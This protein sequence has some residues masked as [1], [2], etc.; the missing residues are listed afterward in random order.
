VNYTFNAGQGWW[1]TSG[2]NQGLRTYNPEIEV[3]VDN[4]NAGYTAYYT[5]GSPSGGFVTFE[6]RS[7]T[8]GIGSMIVVNGTPRFSKTEQFSVGATATAYQ[9]IFIGRVH[10]T[11]SQWKLNGSFHSYNLTISPIVAGNYQAFYTFNYVVPPADIS[12]SSNP[13][14][15]TKISW[16]PPAGTLVDQIQVWRQVRQDKQVVESANVIATLSPTAEQYIDY[17]YAPASGWSECIV[18]YD[19]RTRYRVN[20]TYS[21]ASWFNMFAETDIMPAARQDEV[22]QFAPELPTQFGLSA[23][24]NPF[25]PSTQVTYTLQTNSY[26]EI[27]VFDLEGRLISRL[28]AGSKQPGIYS[29]HW[30]ATDQTGTKVPS[31]IYFVRMLGVTEDG[32]KAIHLTH[33]LILLK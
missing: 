32:G 29:E 4:Y 12:L 33:K 2:S 20:N 19:I 15:G 14:G 16:P 31:G 23:F 9:Y 5:G 21:S 26:V 24:P 18:D 11:F 30:S 17:D 7:D 8:I 22:D 1:K 3:V 6:N 25:N 10:Y 27:S 28:V 13:G